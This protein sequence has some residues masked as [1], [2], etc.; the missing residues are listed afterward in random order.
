MKTIFEEIKI[1]YI[2]LEEGQ[3]EA[4]VDAYI[5]Q[6]GEHF[7]T[8]LVLDSTDLNRL[9]LKL[10]QEGIGLSISD[11]FNCYQTENGKLYTLDM[12]SFGWNTVPIH[13][14]EPKNNVRQIR[15]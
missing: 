2:I 10:N 9:F 12:S 7:N 8:R 6:N 4:T 15:A 14:F 3:Q 5:K 11:N 1:N 13:A